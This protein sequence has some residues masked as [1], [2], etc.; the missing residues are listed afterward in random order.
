MLYEV[1]VTEDE[2]DL[3]IENIIKKY[4]QYIYSLALKLCANPQNAEDLAQETFI[5]AMKFFYRKPMA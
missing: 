1:N 2:L 4:G 5:K 3:S